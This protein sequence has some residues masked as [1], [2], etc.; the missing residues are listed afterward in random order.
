M[1]AMGDFISASAQAAA[2]VGSAMLASSDSSAAD[3]RLPSDEAQPV[4]WHEVAKGD[5]PPESLSMA[6]AAGLS[7]QRSLPALKEASSGGLVWHLLIAPDAAEGG[8]AAAAAPATPAKGKQPV[9]RL[10]PDGSLK[11]R[12]PLPALRAADF[13]GR[14]EKR[15]SG[16]WVLPADPGGVNGWTALSYDLEVISITGKVSGTVLGSTVKRFWAKSDGKLSKAAKG[17]APSEAPFFPP[18]LAFCRAT[19]VRRAGAHVA[20]RGPP[21]WGQERN[22]RCLTPPPPP[23]ARPRPHSGG[24]GVDP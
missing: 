7:R 12:Q 19:V 15:A 24:P 3:G 20:F 9:V 17:V 14:L 4:D 2:E 23:R 1:E 5:D 6:V 10:S 13:F 21:C 11:P 16:A 22:L 8:G 18:G